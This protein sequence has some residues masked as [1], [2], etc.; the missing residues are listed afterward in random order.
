MLATAASATRVLWQERMISSISMSNLP[1]DGALR[2]RAS[3]ERSMPAEPD[4][5]VSRSRIFVDWNHV[6]VI[7]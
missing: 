6:G 2:R 4:G 3:I 1:R 7:L 5:K